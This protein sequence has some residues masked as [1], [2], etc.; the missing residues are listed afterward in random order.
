MAFQVVRETRKGWECFKLSGLDRFLMERDML[1]KRTWYG[2]R[3]I[4]RL[5]KQDRWAGNFRFNRG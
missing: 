3:H 2:H 4:E 5:C 1:N